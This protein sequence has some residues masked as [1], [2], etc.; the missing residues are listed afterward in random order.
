MV[1]GI[2]QRQLALI[3][4]SIESFEKPLF[5]PYIFVFQSG[6][7]ESFDNSGMLFKTL[8]TQNNDG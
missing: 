6:S 8:Y 7:I 1:T 4:N 3:I 5:I 2:F